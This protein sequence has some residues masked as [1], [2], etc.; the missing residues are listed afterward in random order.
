ML[1]AR[2][3]YEISFHSLLFMKAFSFPSFIIVYLWC[4]LLFKSKLHRHQWVSFILILFGL[5]TMIIADSTLDNNGIDHKY[6]SRYI[7]LTIILILIET[8]R[9]VGEK[10]L[11]EKYYFVKMRIM[12]Y[13]ACF[14]LVVFGIMII[15]GSAITINQ[16]TLQ[17]KVFFDFITA[18]PYTWLIFLGFSIDGFL[19]CFFRLSINYHLS[20]H[21]VS[22]SNIIV[23]ILTSIK[24][25]LVDKQ[26]TDNIGYIFWEIVSMVLMSIGSLLF[27]EVIII[28]VCGLAVNTKHEIEKRSI[29]EV[30]I[31]AIEKS[32]PNN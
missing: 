10:Y 18:G 23:Y 6:F 25:L 17:I 1:T 21:Y 24:S 27:N 12:L 15:V 5:S 29:D 4:Y 22:I 31:C 8:V 2:A 28:Y 13:E 32:F 9:D 26:N 3:L 7:I 16:K 19:V 14:C 11:M 30:M 20:P